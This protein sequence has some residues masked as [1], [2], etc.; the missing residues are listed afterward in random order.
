MSGFWKI[1]MSGLGKSS[2]SGPKRVPSPA[3]R[4]NAC[5]MEG[6][7]LTI[8]HGGTDSLARH[9][10]AMEKFWRLHSVHTL[11]LAYCANLYRAGALSPNEM[12]DLR[13]D[14]RAAQN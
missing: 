6:I 5:V 3:P 9:V 11:V 13:I 1:G 4:T 12:Q 8:Q 10:I 7:G 14:D 2:V